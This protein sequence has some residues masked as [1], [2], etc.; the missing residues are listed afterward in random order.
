[1]NKTGGAMNTYKLSN[2]IKREVLN[3]NKMR[4]YTNMKKQKFSFAYLKE[5]CLKYKVSEWTEFEHC[6]RYEDYNCWIE[7]H[8]S[9][10]YIKGESAY[11][12][13]QRVYRSIKGIINSHLTKT[14]IGRRSIFVSENET[15]IFVCM[16]M[17]DTKSKSDHWL[18][19]DKR[20]PILNN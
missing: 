20:Q 8:S 7:V 19:F 11:D 4:H 12:F 13:N 16:P 3:D 15:A 6:C 1:V 9:W 17:R 2:I 10:M 14:Q 18:I 5:I